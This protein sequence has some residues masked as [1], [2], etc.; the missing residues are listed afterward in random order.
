MTLSK[1]SPHSRTDS[2]SG[3]RDL[4]YVFK[5]TMCK[6]KKKKKTPIIPYMK[7]CFNVVKICRTK[8][9]IQC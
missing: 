6:A 5:S 9:S 8:V 2:L 4:L 1:N 7:E 3:P